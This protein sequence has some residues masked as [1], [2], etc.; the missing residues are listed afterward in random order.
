MTTVEKWGLL[1]LTFQGKSEGNPFVDYTISAVF[2][3]EKENIKVDGFYDGEG[4]YKV[5]FMPSFEGA[6]SYKVTGTAL[7]QEET[8]EFQVTAAVAEK[9][10]GPVRVAKKHY[11][12]YED[13]TPY[14]SIGTTCY[15]WV[16]QSEEMQEQTLTTLKNSSFNKI[17]FCFFPKFYIYNLKEPISYPY[18]RGESKGQ[19]PEQVGRKRQMS[20]HLEEPV[21]DITDFDCYQF[22]VEHFKRFDRRIME[23]RD[24]GIEAD[25]ILLHPYDKWGFATMNRECDELYFKYIIARYGAY[26]N[27]WWSLANEYDLMVKTEEDW[28]NYAKIICEKDPYQH[29]RSIHNCGKFY[30]YKRGWITHCSMQRIDLYRHVENTNE[31]LKEYDK[32][33]VWD[34]IAYEGN[35]DMG[36]GNI[37]GEELVRRFWEAFMRGGCAGHGET[38]MHPED[39]IW[40]SHGGVL[41]GISEPRLAFL[42]KIMTE[43]PGGFLKAGR[44]SFDEIVGIPVDEEKPDGRGP[45]VF[46]SYEIH[47]LGFGRPSF[48]N[49]ELPEDRKFKVEVIDT[50]NMTIS[51]RGVHSG[52]TK[53]I[54]PGRQY[55][56][57]RLIEVE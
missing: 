4:T 23:L 39:I 53:I 51:D 3:G 26:R 31:Y 14:Y 7:E 19:D 28:E 27:V 52:Y 44:S 35:V 46:C 29:L 37:T 17:R 33:I 56:A 1:E 11:L 5:R 16:N 12:T 36:W 22:N 15:A 32:P 10:H 2:T 43:T 45:Q 30:D 20:L 55:M 6:Y 57:I 9:N 34:E 47:Y 13:G 25:L 21:A 38:Y 42:Y 48:R 24:L 49:F 18:V 8:G 40:W 50:W 54:M 41:H